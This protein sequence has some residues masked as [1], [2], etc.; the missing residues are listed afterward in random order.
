[1]MAQQI[2]NIE[3]LICQPIIP[4][5][6]KAKLYDLLQAL[7]QVDEPQISQKIYESKIL[8][9]IVIDYSKFENN[10]N[11]LNLLN[12]VVKLICFS[13]CQIPLDQKILFD[14]KLIDSF[15]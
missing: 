11:I 8:N 3:N 14:L 6:I 15:A 1:M 9:F 10:T 4:T 13:K 2:E 5:M 12:G 7:V